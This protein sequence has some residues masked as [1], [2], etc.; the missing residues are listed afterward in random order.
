MNS[1][2]P[3]RKGGGLGCSCSSSAIGDIAKVFSEASASPTLYCLAVVNE[4]WQIFFWVRASFSK[5]GYDSFGWT[6]VVKQE[7]PDALY[8]AQE[9]AVERLVSVS[10]TTTEMRPFPY[11]LE[12]YQ[13]V[14]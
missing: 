3:I 11:C 1:A 4:T 14:W 7:V 9:G 5:N 10:A 12:I 8:Q 2:I 6:T 13:S